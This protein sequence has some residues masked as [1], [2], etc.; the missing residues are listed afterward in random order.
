M[1]HPGIEPGRADLVAGGHSTTEPTMLAYFAWLRVLADAAMSVMSWRW[2]A[3]PPIKGEESG[4]FIM[5][6]CPIV[7]KSL[8]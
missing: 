4:D 1:H 5:L 7:E 6:L 2:P 3:L 8:N